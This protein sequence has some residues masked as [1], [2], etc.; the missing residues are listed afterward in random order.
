MIQAEGFIRRLQSLQEGERSLLR[1]LAGQP[2]DQTL[3]GFDLFTGL[4]WP[5]SQRTERQSAW[6]VAKLFGAFPLPQ[7]RGDHACLPRVL[8]RHEREESNPESFRRRFD[9]LLQSPLSSLEPHL[10]WALWTVGNAIQ[11]KH[12]IG[13]DWV[14]LLDDLSRWDR[15]AEYGRAGDVRDQWAE[16]YLNATSET[17]G[18]EHVD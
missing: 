9:D 8:A 7:V 4:W 16:Q 3:P 18:V 10:R 14:Q 1:R 2:L 5:L 13:F 6:L 15:G 12:A 17:K 11:K